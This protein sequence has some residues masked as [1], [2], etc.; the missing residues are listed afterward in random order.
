MQKVNPVLAIDYIIDN[1]QGP[2][3]LG[4]PGDTEESLLYLKNLKKLEQRFLHP[5]RHERQ[6]EDENADCPKQCLVILVQSIIE[7]NHLSKYALWLRLL[8]QVFSLD[9]NY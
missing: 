3:P 9:S 5:K 7:F 2:L 6:R 4:E 8:G 1:S